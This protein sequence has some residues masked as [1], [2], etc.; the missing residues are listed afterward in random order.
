MPAPEPTSTGKNP[1]IVGRLVV[2][3][4]R[5]RLLCIAQ[6]GGGAGAFAAWRPH[7]PAGV[8]LAPVQRP[9]RG[10]R[11]S[12]PMPDRFE[13][14]VEALHTGLAPELTMPYVLFGHSFGA[15]LAYELTCRIQQSGEA[16][17]RTTVVSASRA[18][19]VPLARGLADASDD[20]LLDWLVSTDGLPAE[21]LGH[22]AFA[23][24]VMRAIRMD[25]RFAEGYHVPQPT[26]VLSPLLAL[27]GEDDDVV[28]SEQVV[29]WKECAAADFRHRTLPGGHSFPQRHPAEVVEALREILLPQD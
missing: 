14:L 6:A 28:P 3:E 26:P 19:Q 29:H 18:P 17:P 24:Y 10:V 11:E 5:V 27:S 8:E 20:T 25:M 23:T 7:L 9:A 15:L 16:P 4:P 12:D 21:V 1:W 2:G 22:R 13:D